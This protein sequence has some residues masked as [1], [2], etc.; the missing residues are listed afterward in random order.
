MLNP[1]HEIP[2]KS[3]SQFITEGQHQ[4]KSNVVNYELSWNGRRYLSKIIH[5]KDVSDRLV[6]DIVVMHDFS[7]LILELHSHVAHVCALYVVI[8]ATLF[9]LFF[10]L[11]G[12]VQQQIATASD[13]LIRTNKAIDSTSDSVLITDMAGKA[14]FQNRSSLELSGYTVEE[15]NEA[16]G[17]VTLY[18]DRAAGENV[19]DIIKRTGSWRGEVELRTLDGRTIPVSFRT[20]G[21]QNATGKTMGMICVYSDITERKRTEEALRESEERYR[22]MMEAMEDAAYICSPDFRIEYMNPAMIKRVGG[23]AVAE[24]CFKAMHGLDEKCP[25]CIHEK[26]MQGHHAKNDVVSPKDGKTYHISS[27]PIFHT[28][29]SISKLTIFRDITE[30]KK[31]GGQLRQSQKM[32]AIGTLA[33][34]IAHDF[35]NILFPMM[36]YAEMMILDLPPDSPVRN[37]VKEIIQ[38]TK[39]AGDLVKQILAFS[40]QADQVLKPLKVQLIIKEVLKLIRSSLPTTIEIKQDISNECGLVLADAIHIHQVAMNLMT[41]AY[42]AMEDEGGKLEINLKEV[43]LEADDLTDPSMTPGA[44]VCLTVADT[45]IGMH[46]SVTSRIF[47][48]YFTT[49]KDGKGT[50]LG[51]AVVHG[52]VKSFGGD[53]RIYS[54]L[55]KG[56]A[57]HVYL[58]VIRP[59]DEIQ[60]AEAVEPVPGGRERIMLVDDEEPIVRMEK[61]LLERLGY[62]VTAKTSSTDALETLRA[63]PASSTL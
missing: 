10:F 61:Q 52:I 62:H 27:S 12:R 8:G 13:K 7:N 15:L 2:I 17:L 4:H 44:Y 31:M 58:P 16:G 33:G 3:L 18:A 43:V 63:S 6:G 50:G 60:E 20:D 41:N 56:T 37:N 25:W 30:I 35:N 46:Q 53:I 39:R 5:L 51:L 59:Q 23:D 29:G 9:L 28:N 26:V 55:G 40:R 19:F 36:G 32:E 24:P 47:E 48:P 1:K 57:F 54:E 38:G 21:I 45:G 34:G 22:S 14:V 49:K 42:H 11:L